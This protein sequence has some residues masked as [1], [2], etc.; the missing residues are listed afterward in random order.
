MSVRTPEIP[1]SARLGGAGSI[2]LAASLWGTTGTV[3]ALAPEGASPVSVGA[4]RIVVGGLL[5]VL[6]ASLV[7][8]GA[9]LR[10]LLSSRRAR[11]LLAV[12]VICVA[13]Y[14]T[15]FFAGVARTGVATGTVVTIGSAPAFAGLLSWLTGGDP[16][17][18]RWLAATAGAVLGCAALI[19]GGQEA[20]VEP[21]GV[22]L[23]LLSGL[24]Y[25]VYATIA[26]H[27]IV[28]GGGDQ[29]V[30]AALFGGAGLLLLPVLLLGSS[31]WMLTGS[32]LLVAGY[33]GGVT[34]AVGYVLYARGLRGT[35]VAVATTLGLAEPAVAALLGLAVLGEDLGGVALVGLAGIGCSLLLLV[36]PERR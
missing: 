13:V 22:A 3:R 20:G 4:A 33:L 14:Q 21:L 2:L 32:G 10:R 6:L 27:L 9:E 28:G 11:L 24:G 30:V 18:R 25:A 7:G 23:A 31:G 35:P 36:L 26:S 29:A 19:G 17:S 5:L 12:G 8:R 34:T 15:A 1:A 16:L